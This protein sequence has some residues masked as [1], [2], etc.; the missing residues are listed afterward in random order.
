MAVLVRAGFQTRAFEER[1]ITLGVPYRVV[2]GLRFYERAGDPRCHRLYARCCRQPA[3]DLAFER[4]VNVP[5]R[6][7]GEVGAARACT[8][9]RA[10]RAFRCREAAARLVASGG[11]KGKAEAAG[12]R[13]AA[14]LRRAGAA[15]WRRDGHVVTVATMLD[16]SG[17][18]EMWKQ[19]KS[20]EAPGRLE[21]LKE[22]VRALADFETL[23]GFL[24]HVALVMENEEMAEADRVSLMTLHGAKGLEFDTVFLPGWEEGLFPN[25]RSMDEGGREG[26][27]GGAA[28][29]LCRP[30]A[31][32]APRHR[33][34][35][36]QP[37]DLRQLAEQHPEPV[38]RT[39]CRMRKW[40][41]PV[42][43]RWRAMRGSPRPTALQR[44]SSRWWRGEAAG[45]RGVGAA[46]PRPRGAMP[47]GRARGCSIRS[48][49]TA[50]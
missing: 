15:C 6:G 38:H 44:G 23:A 14:R 47:S 43:R 26:A 20:P 21:N 24:D 4:I 16:E 22:L 8:R 33:Q 39:S 18:T 32:A 10:P 36:R 3:D 27:G 42:R 29:G 7:V 1:L 30:D 12:R 34:P 13:A 2:G 28:A 35:R 9:W 48:S 17:Y 41:A 37:A 49:A 25:Q 11:L 45:D 40:S 50:R 31:G 19:D 5:R 46:R